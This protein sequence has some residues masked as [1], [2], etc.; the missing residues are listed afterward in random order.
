MN[1]HA[2]QSAGAGRAGGPGC[3]R[4]VW[5]PSRGGRG[6]EKENAPQGKNPTCLQRRTKLSDTPPRPRLNLAPRSSGA[7][8]SPAPRFASPP[9]P[10]APRSMLVRWPRDPAQLRAAL[11]AS[12]GNIERGAG[13][14]GGEATLN[15]GR[16]GNT[17]WRGVSDSFVRRCIVL[18][19][20]PSCTPQKQKKKTRTSPTRSDAPAARAVPP[21]PPRL[22]RKPHAIGYLTFARFSRCDVR[23]C[24]LPD[25]PLRT[26]LPGTVNSQHSMKK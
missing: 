14:G 11:R 8:A 3:A 1:T 10:P 23:P 22:A 24:V 2:Q 7:G 21:A 12:R 26:P 4:R 17:G 18:A 15:G 13:G 6:M 9:P 25:V 20:I 5:G 19:N 16:G